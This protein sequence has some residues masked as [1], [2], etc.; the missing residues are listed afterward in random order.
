MFDWFVEHAVQAPLLAGTER[1]SGQGMRNFLY[2]GTAS[3]NGRLY[4]AEEKHG[5]VMQLPTV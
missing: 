4:I 3:G 2:F 5:L 1:L